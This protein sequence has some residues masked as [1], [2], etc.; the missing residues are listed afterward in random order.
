MSRAFDGALMFAEAGEETRPVCGR[1][2]E[3]EETGFA[4][5]VIPAEDA[6]VTG[7]ATVSVFPSLSRISRRSVPRGTSEVGRS[8]T[9]RMLPLLTAATRSNPTPWLTTLLLF[10]ET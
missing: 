6:V 1:R 10:T 3:S 4:G 9:W 7:R 8:E 5:G 2:F